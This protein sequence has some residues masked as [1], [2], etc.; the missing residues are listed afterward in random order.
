M[1]PQHPQHRTSRSNRR[2]CVVADGISKVPTLLPDLVDQRMD[3]DTLPVSMGR[4][5]ITEARMSQVAKVSLSY[6]SFV[7]RDRS[8]YPNWN[9]T[10]GH[11]FFFAQNSSR[12]I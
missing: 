10:V 12:E 5:C 11:Y 2:H 1:L 9:E 6:S 8:R 4:P 3:D 7:C